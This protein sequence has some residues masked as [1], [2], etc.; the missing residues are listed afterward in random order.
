MPEGVP[1]EAKCCRWQGAEAWRERVPPMV[2]ERFG[3][4]VASM[5]EGK[6]FMC[7]HVCLSL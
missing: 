2:R 4:R 5:S 6:Q 1:L 3:L 7:M